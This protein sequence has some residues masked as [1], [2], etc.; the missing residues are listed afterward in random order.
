LEIVTVW[1]EQRQTKGEE[2]PSPALSLVEVRQQ[3]VLMEFGE[4][5]DRLTHW[6]LLSSVLLQLEQEGSS[7]AANTDS[8]SSHVVSGG[9]GDCWSLRKCLVPLQRVLASWPK[10]QQRANRVGSDTQ[11]SKLEDAIVGEGFVHEAALP[12]PTSTSSPPLWKQSAQDAAVESLRRSLK[13]LVSILDSG[14]GAKTFA[15]SSK[16]D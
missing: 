16:A 15:F 1:K 13:T 8:N 11:K 9:G 2:G 7:S 14:C 3:H 10:Q 12:P 6:P 4:L 5:V